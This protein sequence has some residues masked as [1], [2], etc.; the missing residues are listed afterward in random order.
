MANLLLTISEVNS[1]KDGCTFHLDG[2]EAL[3]I[4]SQSLKDGGSH[5][6]S[7]HKASHSAG[8]TTSIGSTRL[9]IY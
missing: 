2:L 1:G 9:R 3:G 5:L 6:D 8:Y 7:F 4:E